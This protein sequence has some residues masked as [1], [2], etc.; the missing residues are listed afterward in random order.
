MPK[1]QCKRSANIAGNR[2]YNITKIHIPVV[3]YD[4]DV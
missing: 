4:E 3:F 2:A 1:G